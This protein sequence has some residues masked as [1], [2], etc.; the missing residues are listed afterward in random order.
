MP[1][2]R[3]IKKYIG[4]DLWYAFDWSQELAGATIESSTFEADAGLIVVDDAVN[5]LETRVKL[6]DAEQV[7]LFVVT[8]QVT[9]AD[10]ETAVWPLLVDVVEPTA[11]PAKPTTQDLLDSI[12][13][14]ILGNRSGIRVSEYRGRRIERMSLGELL[15]AR[16]RLQAEL[17]RS[18]RG[19]VFNVADFGRPAQ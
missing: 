1:Q 17:A 7:G 5:G 4:S 10:G 12:E 18:R 19:S 8:N 6:T 9:T 14:A 15:D 13:A 16:T 2:T 11:K 3:Q